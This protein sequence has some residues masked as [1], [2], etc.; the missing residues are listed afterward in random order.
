[1]GGRTGGRR[2]WPPRLPVPASLRPGKGNGRRGLVP[3]GLGKVRS[4]PIAPELQGGGGSPA[5]VPTA[6][7]TLLT[8]K[9]RQPSHEFTSV[10]A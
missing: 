2:W 8:V 5:P 4:Y 9:I 7:E 1:V 10:L 3:G 6:R